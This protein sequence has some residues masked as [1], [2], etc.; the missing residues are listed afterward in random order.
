MGCTP[1][2]KEKKGDDATRLTEVRPWYVS[3]V[4]YGANHGGRAHHFALKAA[5]LTKRVPAV[6]AEPDDKQKALKERADAYG[7]AARDDA[8][9]S[10][11]AG[12]PTTENLYGDPVNLKYPLGGENNEADPDRIR[13]AVARFKQNAGEYGDDASRGRV[14]ARIV[15]AAMDAGID[16]SYDPAD[17]IDALLPVDVRDALAAKAAPP[18]PPALETVDKGAVAAARET[19]TAIAARVDLAAVSRRVVVAPPV[20][21]PAGS[22]DETSG[23]R[24]TVN[25]ADRV[26]E[27]ENEK[28]TLAGRLQALEKKM[29]EMIAK[30]ARPTRTAGRPL[31]A[32]HPAGAEDAIS[33]GEATAGPGYP[34]RYEGRA[35]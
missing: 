1:K 14:Y 17:P 31:A 20:P 29:Q 28:A 26:A 11:P 5:V 27:L 12:D 15:R 10:Y 34:A 22:L 4:D 19:I 16:V 2:D 24:G 25:Q 21:N 3:L 8:A 9:L 6:D 13:N 7:I 18:P 30:T 33:K 23:G 32:M 35:R